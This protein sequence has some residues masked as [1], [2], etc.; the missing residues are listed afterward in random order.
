MCYKTAVFYVCFTDKCANNKLL[1]TKASESG[2]LW[3]RQRNLP[4]MMRSIELGFTAQ[5]PDGMELWKLHHLSKVWFLSPLTAVYLGRHR[6]AFHVSGT[7]LA[8]DTRMG[9]EGLAWL[10]GAG[11][12]QGQWLPLTECL[13]CTKHVYLR[14]TDIIS[15][16]PPNSAK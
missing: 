2:C 4:T 7:V 13:F 6:G 16:N 3:A 9:K 15:A 5:A 11:Q 14:S 10:P 1:T 12:M 8:E